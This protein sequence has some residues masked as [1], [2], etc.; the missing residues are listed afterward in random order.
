MWTK[1]IKS[2]VFTRVKTIGT[3]RLEK[4]FP[5]INFTTSSKASTMPKFPTVYVKQ[6]QGAEQGQ[7]LEGTSI[8]GIM[9]GFQIDVTDNQS[10]NN[11]YTVADVVLEIMKSMGFDV[12]G[13]PFSDDTGDG[14][15]VT[16]RY[17]RIIGANDIF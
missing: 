17:Q 16:S 14:Y 5:N 9:A 7:T 4:Q 8:N 10:E 11:A 3:E 2:K 15:R 1:Y 6:L 12:I 13:S